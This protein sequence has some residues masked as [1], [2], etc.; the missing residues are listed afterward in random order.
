MRKEKEIEVVKLMID[1]YCRG[2]HKRKKELC[3]ECEELWQYAKARREK[4][5]F[6]DEKTFCSN[7]KIHCY[8]PSMREKIAKVMRYSGPRMMFYHPVIAFK[9]VAE[10][11]KYKRK[12]KKEQEGVKVKND[13]EKD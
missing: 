1:V 11:M 4:C 3:E 10:T 6:G 5:P 9:H 7:C 12:A 13:E 8:K 2:K